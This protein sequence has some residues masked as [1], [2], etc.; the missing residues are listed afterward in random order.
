MQALLL[1]CIILSISTA[2]RDSDFKINA[3]PA[4]PSVLACYHSDHQIDSIRLSRGLSP[5]LESI[6]TLLFCHTSRPLHQPR[7]RLSFGWSLLLLLAGD[8]ST[9]PGPRACGR[10]LRLGTVNV[11][12]MR[13]KSAVL[14]DLVV[15]QRIDLLGITE[16]WLTARETLSD[17]TEL[18]P[19]GFSFF[20]IPR[21][22]RRG[23]GVG[24]FV[25]SAHKFTPITLPAHTSF[26]SI[27][28]KVEFGQLC[29]NVL[30]IYR[31]P[32]PTGVFLSEFQDI[33]S[34]MST[35]P[36][37]LVVMGDF[38]LHVDTPSSDVGQLSD[39][40]ESFD[41]DQRVDFPTHIYGHSLDLMIFSKGLDVL[42]VSASDKISDHFSVL[43]DLNI[44]SKNSRSVPK[45]I[46]YRNLKAINM[47][48]FRTGILNSDLITSPKGNAAELV[49]QYDT[50]LRNLLDAHA[51]LITKTIHPKPPNPWINP[52]I[53]E[54]KRQ[55]RYLER[56]WRK[57]PTALN[58]S[59]LTRQTHLCN[60]LMA[61]AKSAHYSK[62]INDHSG[63]H[64]SLWKAFNKV[65]HRG[66]IMHLPGH[67]SIA[68]LAETF[69][70]FFINKI[71]IIRAAFPSHAH[72]NT[73]NLHP[74]DT[75]AELRDFVPASQAEV[76]RLVLSSPSK[77]CD[78]DPIPTTLLKDC[79][80]ILVT[81]I[82]SIVNLSLLEGVFPACFKTAHVSPLLK[83]STLDTENMR[84]YR[85]VSNLSFLS[86]VLERAVARRLYA[87]LSGTNTFNPFQSAYRKSHS[88]E[89]ALL[90]IHNDIISS[91]DDG[92]VTALTLL[93]LSAAFDTID[94]SIL[95]GRLQ[96]WVGATGVALDWLRSYLTGRCQRIKLG[97]CLSPKVD[98]PFGVPQG[99]VLGPLLFTIYTSPLSQVISRHGI[100]HHFYADDSQ[101][102]VSFSSSNSAVS[103]NNLKSCLDSVQLWMS[104]NKLKLNPDKTEFLLIGHE[105]QRSKYLAMFPVDL[106]GVQTGPAKTARNLGVI[107]DKNFS[108]RSHVSAVCKSCRYHIRDLRRIRR[109][110]TLD[111]AKLLAHALVSSRLDYCNSLLFGIADKEIK[112]LQ[113]IQNSLAR[114]VT[115]KPLMT[116]SIPLLRSLHWL[117][118]KFRI[119]FK[120]CLLTYNTLN[121]KQP[122]YLNAILTPSTPA[123]LLRSHNGTNLSVPRVK[124]S[125][126]ARA[127]RSGA[128]TL[129]NMLPVPV[130]SAPSTTTFKQRL[131][132][133]LFGLAFPP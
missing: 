71:S 88:T 123:R 115:K 100:L 84:N 24:L 57:N 130:R 42:S 110:L 94:H 67:S 114:V 62:F 21:A 55:R 43:A 59:R 19:P 98:L 7:V 51:P 32:G 125:T 132:T 30:N 4:S 15:S 48:A 116:S 120:I 90:N 8:V 93:D 56:V 2:C 75:R 33:L 6:P 18:T 80:D 23:G 68:A 99:S 91:M 52:D 72:L 74:P 86:K 22:I 66:P 82:T 124:T 118:I 63:D 126:G 73:N 27:S 46:R 28:G 37:D 87:H 119:K 131:K 77:S 50:V 12:S 61:K 104:A 25:S 117:P 16:T 111:S 121:E 35:L 79:I 112:R 85:P 44:P 109:Y 11:R 107:F 101:L 34:H 70:S 69:G 60:K 20:Q 133:H 78:L 64:R 39:I 47:E 103:L 36:H 45:T 122:G 40:L 97:E 76:R 31:Q 17:L 58:R 113:C 54:T 13:D 129:W 3:P 49:E 53:L 96:D 10:N 38:N 14:S 102:Y 81:P 1:G 95:L 128:P 65:L 106:L 83:K 29:L 89:T 9:N 105:R 5:S 26:E 108:F 92:K 41:L 127:F